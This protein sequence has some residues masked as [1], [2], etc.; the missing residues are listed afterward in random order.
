[1]SIML[2]VVSSMLQIMQRHLPTNVSTSACYTARRAL[3]AKVSV[4]A[5]SCCESQLHSSSYASL[6]HDMC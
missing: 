4:T 6:E 1:M 3:H 2:Q 5:L